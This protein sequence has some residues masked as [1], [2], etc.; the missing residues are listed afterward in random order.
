MK[1]LLSRISS[2]ETQANEHPKDT[3]LPFY[4]ASI[5]SILRKNH[6][7]E[8]IDNDICRFSFLA[9]IEKISTMD[10]DI[11]IIEFSSGIQ[12]ETGKLIKKIKNINRKIK[13]IVF[14]SYTDYLPEKFLK[15]FPADFII[16][17]EPESSIKKLVSEIALGGNNFQKLINIPNLVFK[18]KNKIIRTKKEI[19]GN[20]NSLPQMAHD[21]FDSSKYQIVSKNVYVK[22]KLKWGFILSSRGCPF[23]CIFCSP[24]I[25]NST[26]KIYRPRNIGL[27]VKE[28]KYLVDNLY[29]NAISFEDDIFTID[30]IRT[31]ELCQKIIEKNIKFSW[32]ISTRADQLD[33]KT[34]SLLK[35]AGCAGAAIGIESGDNN[36][37]KRIN[38]GETVEQIEKGLQLLNK[39]K[40]AITANIIIGHPE[41]T[42]KEINKTI[43][44]IKKVQPI[45]LHLHYLTP[46]PGTKIHEKYIRSKYKFNH[47]LYNNF[48][49]SNIPDKKYKKLI[50]KIYISYYLNP[51]YFLTYL[52]YRLIYWFYNPIFEKNLILNTLKYLIR[53]EK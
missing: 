32:C 49:I 29:V 21:L 44:F 3:F 42:L 16:V 28:I 33:E 10:P 27:I 6:Q 12:K 43:S 45:F 36:V 7:I 46:Y 30:K 23:Q 11:A 47:T 25:R 13:I 50:K 4:L 34:V 14:G 53:H 40:I 5:A 38:K 8:I 26:G 19:I 41:E 18:L 1:I 20:I 15:N 17:N 22:K 37:L 51:R 35:K 48:N 31:Q 2:F 9:L 39:Y 52:K 24:A